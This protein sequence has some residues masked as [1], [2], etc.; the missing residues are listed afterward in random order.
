MDA[1]GGPG[2][3]HVEAGTV[4]GE[5]QAVRPVEVGHDGLDPARRGVDPVDGRGQFLVG[6]PAL[7]V[8][9]DPVAGV[10][11]PDGAVRG[12]RD[13]VRRVE[14]AAVIPVRQHRDRAVVFGPG[15]PPAEV[16]AGDEPTQPV[17]GVPVGV[18]RRCPEHADAA[19][20]GVPPQ[21]IQ[22]EYGFKIVTFDDSANMYDDVKTGNSQAVFDDYP[23]L[24]Y[25]VA[26]GNGLQIVTEKEVGGSYGFAVAKGE[27]GELLEQFNDGLANLEESGEYQ[28]ILD[29]YLEAKKSTDTENGFFGLLKESF[30]SLMKGL[31]MTLLLTVVSLVIASILGILFGLC[32]VAHNAVLRAIGTIYVDIFRGTP[33][34]VQAFFIYFGLPAALDFRI[35]AVTAGIITL[36]LNAG[37]YMAEIVRGGIESV[38]KGQME[39]ARSLGLP[40]KT[41]MAKV[42]L[43]QAIRLMI[44]SII[45]Q[46]IITLKDTSILSIIGIN[47]LTQSGKIIIARNLES[48][49]MW[50]IVGVMYFIIIMILTKV[51]NRMERKI[52]NG[53]A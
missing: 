37:A 15:H 2:V 31:Q 46:F 39:A 35:S 40:Y 9:H 44:P 17:P 4:R 38:D 33:L 13:V 14:T 20:H 34:I 42:I 1:P 7:V 19:C 27:N 43:P 41:A 30:P 21:H 23:V 8:R 24:A 22:D 49:Q 26:Q 29:K 5:A 47:E 3:D 52:Q 50:L 12:D 11:E 10:G 36:S 45:N 16:L 28:E 6:L 25:G 32:R 48:F 51:S 18:V 53:K